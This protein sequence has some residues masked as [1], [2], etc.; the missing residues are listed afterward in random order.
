MG[1]V[2]LMNKPSNKLKPYSGSPV[3]FDAWAK[4]FVNHALADLFKGNLHG[5]FNHIN[6]QVSR[7]PAFAT[8]GSSVVGERQKRVPTRLPDAMYDVSVLGL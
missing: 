6:K 1:C 2:K 3:D 7:I 8:A 4:T 5:H